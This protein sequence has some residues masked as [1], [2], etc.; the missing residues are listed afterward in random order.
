MA[1]SGKI[2][3]LTKDVKFCT[4]CYNP[5]YV[6]FNFTYFTAPKGFI[7]KYK[8]QMLDRMITLSSEPFVTIMNFPKNIGFEFEFLDIHKEI[9]EQFKARFDLN[10]CEKFAIMRLYPNNNPVVGRIVGIIV[11]NIF[12][13]MFLFLGDNTGYKR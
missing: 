7:G 10:Q 9:P 4:N 13:V 5:R 3:K 8:A 12:Y 1:K 11:H 2:K 6:K